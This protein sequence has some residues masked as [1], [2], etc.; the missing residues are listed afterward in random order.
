MQ[1]EPQ[2]QQ[3]PLTQLEVLQI[4]ADVSNTLRDAATNLEKAVKQKD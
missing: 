2:G 1:E 3:E 4:F